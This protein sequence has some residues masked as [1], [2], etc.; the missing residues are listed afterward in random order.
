MTSGGDT[1]EDLALP[2]DTDDDQKMANG[3]K[4]DFADSKEI[5]VSIVKV[6]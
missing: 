6:S 4:S 1:R 2:K 3:I 5:L